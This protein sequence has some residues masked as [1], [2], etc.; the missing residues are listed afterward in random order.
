MPQGYPTVPGALRL[1]D[2][3]FEVLLSVAEEALEGAVVVV[4]R[5]CGLKVEL[6]RPSMAAAL[7]K[8]NILGAN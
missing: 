1:T 7:K 5:L 8:S 4:G 3:V 2:V 6:A